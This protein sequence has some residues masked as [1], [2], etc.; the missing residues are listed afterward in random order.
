MSRIEQAL[1]R[2]DRTAG[3]SKDAG[4]S[5]EARRSRESGLEDYPLEPAGRLPETKREQ[6]PTPARPIVRE[7]RAPDP[8]ASENAPERTLVRAD[9]KPELPSRVLET[10]ADGRL[11]VA[12]DASSVW[13]EQYR[14]LAA[15]LYQVQRETALK[16][17][18]VSSAL[19][20][21]GKTLTI[22]NLALTL[23][24]SYGQRVLLIDADLR[25]PS[26]HDIFGVSNAKGLSEYLRADA[27]EPPIVDV[28]PTLSV[29]PGGEPNSNPIA[30]LV[31]DRMKRLVEQA[32]SR[33]AWV[34]VDTPPVGLLPDANLLARLAGGVIF[35]V[36]ASSSPYPVVQRAIAAIGPE[37]IIGVVLNRAAES[38]LPSGTHYSNYSAAAGRL[39][40]AGKH[41]G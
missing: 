19:P 27:M 7:E 2:A 24:E 1:R 18:M 35:V 20:R 15:T 38:M 9:A 31:S 14:Q 5:G 28:S 41:H 30:G 8:P 3:V 10:A 33:F 16:T 6:S 13:I 40:T 12:P 25:N 4:P 22:A 21:E 34:L 36:A 23:S 26:I 39:S 29:M 32:E 11:V 17:V 37:R